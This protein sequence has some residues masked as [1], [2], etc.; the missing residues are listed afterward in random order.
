MGRNAIALGWPGE[1]DF[2]VMELGG[3]LVIF[4]GRAHVVRYLFINCQQA[5]DG[6]TVL[7]LLPDKTQIS[8]MTILGHGDQWSRPP[9][10]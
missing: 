6:S 5:L 7:T 10:K 9:R 2:G 4:K 3:G 8:A 1:Q